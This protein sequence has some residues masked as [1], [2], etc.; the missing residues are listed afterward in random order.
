[1]FI[2]YPT[3]FRHPIAQFTA[4]TSRVSSC[5]F[6]RH[7]AGHPASPERI[8]FKDVWSAA[9]DIGEWLRGLGLGL[10]E[11]SFRE[12]KIDAE[13]L[14][15]LTTDDLKELG[16]VAVGDRR[17][18]LAAI[19]ALAAHSQEVPGLTKPTEILAERRPV[20]VLF[21][22][23]V[24]ST[25]LAAKLDVEDWRDLV[26][27]YL[28]VASKAVTEAGGYVLK[29][30]GDGLMALFGYPQAEENDAERAVWSALAT[31][32]AIDEINARQ[33]QTD[34]PRLIARIGLESGPVVVDS[35]GEVFG[36]VPNVAARVQAVAAPGTVLVTSTVQRQISGLFVVEDMGPHEL[37]GVPAPVTLYRILR[38]TGGRRKKG[39]RAL[40]RFVGREED[41]GVLVRRWGSARAG[42]GQVVLIAGEPGIGKSRLVEEFRSRLG[43][44]PHT[45]IEWSSSQLLQNTPLHPLTEWGRVRFGGLAP[46]RRLAEL[47]SMLAQI[48][49]DPAEYAPLIAPLVDIP[50]P[51]EQ[52]PNLPPDEARRRQLSAMVAS[53]IAAARVQPLILVFEDLQWT[54]PTSV[55]LIQALTE[56]GA[57]APLLILATMR[58]EFRPPWRLRSHHTVISLTPLGVAQVR[59][60]VVDIAPRQALSNDVVDG[61]SERA[62]GVPLFVEEL[63]RLL[64]ERGEQGGAQAIPPTLRQSL[65]ARLDRLGSAR[66][67][68][69]IGAVLGRSF[70]YALVH[71]V[72]I[73]ATPVDHSRVGA[74]EGGYQGPDEM[75]LHSALDQLV[76]A[77]LLFVEGFRPEATYSFKHALIQD[78]AYDSLLKTHR[79]ALHRRAADAL[80]A[81]RGEP[82]LIARHLTEAGLDDLAIDSWGKA[83]E[84]ALRRSAFKEAIAHL[85]KAIAMAERAR[86]GTSKREPGD[87]ASNRLLKLH[88]DYGHAAMWLRGFA[89]DEMSTAYARASEFAGPADE[90]GARF[91]A[92]YAQC[93]SGFM[94][95]E[96]RT[97]GERAEA[98]LRDAEAEERFTEVGVARRVLGFISLNQGDLKAAQSFL[99]RALSDYVPERDR[100]ALFRFGNDTQVSASN[101]LALTDWHLGE[102]EDA[103]RLIDHSTR[104]AIELGHVAAVGSALFF[105][106][107]IE[108]RRND[109]S[110]ALVA[111]ES[112]V[113]LTQ[114]HDM[115]TYADLGPLYLNWARGRLTDPEAA[116]LGLERALES[117]LALGNRS[118]APS[119]YGLL[120]ELQAAARSYDRALTEVA[121]GLSVAD[122]TGEHYTDS[123]L[124][125]LRGEILL[126]CDHADHLLA[127]EAFK[128]AIAIAKAQG[129]RGYGLF[130]SLSLAKLYE[131]TG[132]AI[133]A[134]SVLAP[135]LV[136]FTPTP[137][138]PEIAEAGVL[139]KASAA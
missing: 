120:A 109:V 137:E 87:A 14:P 3:P 89:A 116:A 19:E 37:K 76:A 47:E 124:H 8:S 68:A 66:E 59:S 112:L 31:H 1:M 64:L 58:P 70:S 127:E 22:D 121:H 48:K 32:R 43:E 49:L 103:R 91:V 90:T 138:M 79:Q 44:D 126:T 106:T 18:L 5:N 53:T 96:Y 34:A 101:F 51:P 69:Q 57:Q 73:G 54:D 78:A 88:T 42:D 46:E 95:G 25:S 11:R 7:A 24:G 74:T 20:T 86:E 21:C 132:R 125:R 133:Q 113:A 119:F 15:R 13:V 60:M 111:A 135:A 115:K 117:Y 83:G 28:D 110:A 67:V 128:A 23:L 27:E 50:V 36:E 107:L 104:A 52:L 100:S 105:K 97:A 10:Y 114:E 75:S 94:R 77:D 80:I 29:R 65:A 40:T 2:E 84:L 108:S 38:A 72:A 41:L 131:S 56:Q 102:V 33:A 35:T 62:G 92:Y 81:A 139:L 9:M 4:Y 16:V 45:W 63:T 85:S 122:G 99:E 136:G 55:D 123:Y 26:N 17:K 39:A 6:A 82:E 61:L 118:G 12:N 30:L 130:A 98:F 134:R 71:E 93:L 129:A